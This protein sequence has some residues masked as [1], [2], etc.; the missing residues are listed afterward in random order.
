MNN[1]LIREQRLDKNG[2][3]NTKLVRN[4]NTPSAA[5]KVPAP[6]L[7]TTTPKAKAYK[8]TANQKAQRN[9]QIESRDFQTDPRLADIVGIQKDWRQRHHYKFRA[10]DVEMYGVYSVTTMTNAA[11][12]MSHGILS[13]EDALEFIHENGLERII[14]DRSEIMDGLLQRKIT[15][16]TL[17]HFDMEH[18]MSNVEDP[19]LVLDAVEVYSVKGYKHIMVSSKRNSSVDPDLTERV[20][21]GEIALND[22]KAFGAGRLKASSDYMAIVYALESIKKGSVDY[23]A[24]QLRNY[25]ERSGKDLTHTDAIALANAYGVRFVENLRFQYQAR[26]MHEHITYS[27]LGTQERRDLMLFN[28][29]FHMGL[30]NKNLHVK[31]QDVIDLSQSGV[32]AL[33]AGRM[34]GAGRTVQE[35]LAIHKEGIAPSIADGWL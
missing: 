24:V 34:I 23:T 5:L 11:A 18:E 16:Q 30:N 2:K 12:L 27:E 10:S 8:P 4:G 14:R 29:F 33:H 28:D 6:T 21:T 9:Y 3:L 7:G 32:E 26:M 22:L 25:L 20:L 15:A 31:R 19:Q 1:N 17:I 35:V 13:K